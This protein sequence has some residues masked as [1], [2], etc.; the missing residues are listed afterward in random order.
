MA[1]CAQQRVDD[2]CALFAPRRQ[3]LDA[4]DIESKLSK[5]LRVTR[6]QGVG[7]RDRRRAPGG[8][9]AEVSPPPPPEPVLLEWPAPLPAGRVNRSE[10]SGNPVGPEAC[11]GVL[12]SAVRK[13][14]TKLS[15]CAG[16]GPGP[17]ALAASE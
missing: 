6:T 3:G 17:L 14:L 2:V 16:D 4:L 7:T 5:D 1:G 10:D 8:L 15:I 9:A 13:L 12:A 11:P